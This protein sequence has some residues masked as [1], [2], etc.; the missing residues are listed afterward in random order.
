M[1]RRAMAFAVMGAFMASAFV[2]GPVVTAE[3]RAED[4][5][6]LAGRNVITGSRT[7]HVPV[8]VPRPTTIDVR[9]SLRRAGGPNPS[10]AV[11]GNGPF[12][13]IVLTQ[14]EPDEADPLL[15]A[16]RF[17]E[18]AGPACPR[19]RAPINHVYPAAGEEIGG[20]KTPP[21]LR[22][23]AGDYRLYLIADEG[24]AQV[25]VRLSGLPGTRLVAP[26]VEAPGITRRPEVRKDIN[27]G[28]AYYGAGWDFMGGRNGI[29][30]GM[31][32]FRSEN[33]AGEYGACRYKG[34]APPPEQIAYG[35]QCGALTATPI[36]DGA[37]VD[38]A[39]GDA[40]TDRFTLKAMFS[41]DG[42]SL[43]P[44]PRGHY[45][46]GLWYRSS[47]PVQR[48]TSQAFY[49]S[50]DD[51]A[52]L[53]ERKKDTR[54]EGGKRIT[55]WHYE[56]PAI[57]AAGLGVCT[58]PIHACALFQTNR[59]ES[60]VELKIEDATGLPVLASVSERV[61]GGSLTTVGTVCGETEEPLQI[62]PGAELV[63]FPWAIGRASCPGPATTG[64][65]VAT[66]SR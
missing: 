30:V 21:N 48:P 22:V 60:L 49:L 3:A 7:A 25:T 5:V 55:E 58:H 26:R 44:N 32:Q 18:C 19:G 41:W 20:S 62:T 66:F 29:W 35:V 37:R 57:G 53:P 34:P 33:Y 59:N 56:G 50:F 12:V 64:T 15:V 24:P 51:D 11:K 10:I 42:S 63:I 47:V 36:G 14:D 38:V 27:T 16:G 13:G 46:A 54:F 23:P 39:A 65:V 2:Y 45:G 17:H 6:T 52:P 9:E 28:G 31:L 61:D 4:R 8:R 40:D 43:P 1:R